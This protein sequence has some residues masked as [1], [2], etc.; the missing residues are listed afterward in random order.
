MGSGINR[1]ILHLRSV[2]SFL[3]TSTLLTYPEL[4]DGTPDYMGETAVHFE[5]IEGE[6]FD[7]LSSD[8]FDTLYSFLPEDREGEYMP[9]YRNQSRPYT[10]DQA[11]MWEDAD[12][13]DYPNSNLKKF[14]KEDK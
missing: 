10:A 6:W 7:C 11:L 2:G 8:D 12:V 3:D 9:L 14:L 4:S 13:Y 1:M 5:D